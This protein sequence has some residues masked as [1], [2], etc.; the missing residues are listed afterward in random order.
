MTKCRP[1]VLLFSKDPDMRKKARTLLS[2]NG[3]VCTT[4]QSIRHLLRYLLWEK[5]D[6]LI[7]DF[8]SMKQVPTAAIKLLIRKRLTRKIICIV[9]NGTSPEN[10]I[11]KSTILKKPFEP[12]QLLHAVHRTI[13]NAKINAPLTLNIVTSKPSRHDNG[14]LREKLE[15]IIPRRDHITGLPIFSEFY[16][17]LSQLRQWCRKRRTSCTAMVLDLDNFHKINLEFGYEFGNG[18]LADIADRFNKELGNEIY[19]ARGNGDEFILLIP[20]SSPTR[21]DELSWKIRKTVAG[22]PVE[23]AGKTAR[24]SVSI[25]VAETDPIFS[26]SE[27]ELIER[28]RAAARVASQTGQS[29]VVKY[30]E[31]ML[32]TN[33]DNKFHDRRATSGPNYLKRILIEAISALTRTVE[34]KDPYTRK[35]SDHVAFYAEHL[36]KFINLDKKDVEAIRIAGLLHDIGKIAVPDAIL[37]KPGK[38]SKEEFN[39]IRRHPEIGSAIVEN[40]TYMKDESNLILHHHERWDGKGYPVGLRGEQIPLGARILAIADSI[41]AMLMERTY[42]RAYTIDEMLAELRRCAGSQFDPNLAQQ[43][44]LWCKQNPTLLIQ[45]PLKESSKLA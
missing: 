14:S 13:V 1:K 27:S 37:T 17:R 23:W 31:G 28:A 26:I 25:G 15:H 30:V 9:D 32:S 43:A 42:R 24:L 20:T 45:P 7:L 8:S 22:A 36:A 10:L 5:Y 34:A 2:D 19:L 6:A 44:I 41:D 35:H 18:V 4:I 29:T 33:D 40:I 16:K 11:R 38:L 12:S 39:F 21:I 3:I